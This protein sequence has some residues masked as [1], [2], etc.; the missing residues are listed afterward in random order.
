VVAWRTWGMQTPLRQFNGIPEDVLH[1]IEKKDI[2]WENYYEL[3]ETELGELIHVPKL[4]KNL[5]RIIHIFPKLEITAHILPITRNSIQLNLTLTPNFNW[6]ERI[7]S[8]IEPFWVIVED[9]DSEK[10]FKSRVFYAY[11]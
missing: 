9:T 4:G 5:Y 11:T 10:I 3:T 2:D 8:S 7:H 6:D 1:K